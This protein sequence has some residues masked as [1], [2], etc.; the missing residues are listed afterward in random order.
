MMEA[1]MHHELPTLVPACDGNASY[2][3]RQTL[4]RNSPTYKGLRSLCEEDRIMGQSRLS[5]V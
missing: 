4:M 1:L 5:P 3:G 2:A